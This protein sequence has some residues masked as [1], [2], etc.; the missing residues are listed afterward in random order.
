MTFHTLY[1]IFSSSSACSCTLLSFSNFRSPIDSFPFLIFQFSLTIFQF[2]LTIFQFSLTIFQFSLTIFQFS[3][4]CSLTT[5]R[6]SYALTTAPMPLAVPIEAKPATPAPGRR[7][8]RVSRMRAIES[9]KVTKKKVTENVCMCVC[10]CVCVER[11]IEAVTQRKESQNKE[12]GD[13]S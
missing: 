3:L 6:T 11:K 13:D 9:E 7:E 4:T 1:A 2:S 12:M 10:V 5:G 8:G